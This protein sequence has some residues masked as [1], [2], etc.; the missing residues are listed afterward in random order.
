LADFVSRQEAG[1]DI[2]TSGQNL[3]EFDFESGAGSNRRQK[4]RDA[5]FA[6][7]RVGRDDLLVVR[8]RAAARPY[9]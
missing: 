7:L 3:L 9:R 1:N 2:G 5:L 6:C 4:I 8:G